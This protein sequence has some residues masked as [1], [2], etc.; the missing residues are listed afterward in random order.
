MSTTITISDTTLK[1]L[2]ELSEGTNDVEQSLQRLVT[3]EYHRRLAR[4]R[5]TDQRL[6]QKYGM[7]FAEFER[8]EMTRRHD[9]SWDV[10]SDAIAWETAIDGIDTIERRLSD[11][12][13]PTHDN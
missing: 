7:S 5:L 10:E 4:Y 11:I 1:G 3:A 9:Y 8:D 13:S 2:Q 6:A 12:P